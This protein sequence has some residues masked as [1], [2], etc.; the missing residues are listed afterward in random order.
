MSIEGFRPALQQTRHWRIAPHA[1]AHLRAELPA[2]IDPQR[3]HAALGQLLARHE[4][5]RTRLTAVPGMQLPVQVIAEELNFSWQVVE[6]STADAE[7]RLQ[8]ELAAS[9]AN[10][11][12]PPLAAALLCNGPSNQLLLALPAANADAETLELLLSELAALYQGQPLD[13]EPV[14]YADFAEWQHELISGPDGDAGRAFWQRQQAAELLSPVHP[15]QNP[16]AEQGYRPARIEKNLSASAHDRLHSTL[17]GLAT[18]PATVFGLCWAAL[19]QR[20]LGLPR[21]LLGCCHAGRNDAT[22]TAFG[23]YAKALP[24]LFAVDENQSLAALCGEFG[25]L[26]AEAEAWQESWPGEA[27]GLPFSFRYSQSTPCAWPIAELQADGDPAT[28]MLDV[29][30]RDGQFAFAL[31]YDASRFTGH[32]AELILEQFLS[33]CEQACSASQRPL[34]EASGIGAR[35]AEW[36]AELN[37][38]EAHIAAPALLHQLFEAQIEAN[39]TAIALSH[40]GVQLSYA[41]LE[42]QANRLAHRLR[43][44]GL[45]A[46]QP[47]GLFLGR[48]SEAIV[49][50]LGILKAGGAYLPLDPAY[51]AERLADMLEQTQAPLLL[52]VSAL[53]ERLPVG[54][55]QTLW[56]DGEDDAELP[57]Q[58][59][60]AIGH[61]DQLA[62]L[63]FT[64]G[65]TGRPKGVMVSHR[66]AVHSTSARWLGYQEPLASFLLVSGLAFDS[67]VAGLFWSLSQGGTLC[68]PQD[69]QVQDTLALGRLIAE[70]RISHCL[71]LPSLY[72]QVLE[73][74]GEHLSSLRCA[75]VAGEA[76]QA[77]VA[78]RHHE[79]C[80]GAALYNEYGP[81]EGSVWCSLYRSRGEEQ[82]VL[83]IGRAIANMRVQVLDER[84]QAVAPGVAGEIYIGGAGITQGYLGRP[85]L[86]AERYL[87]DPFG[88]PG[89]RLYRSG[90][91]GRLNAEGELEF[92][93]RVD[94][95][96]KIRGF[97]IELGEIEA[98]LLEH[99][100]L[101][102]AAVIARQ[103]PA[104]DAELVAYI[105]ARD[106]CP[107]AQTLRQHLA[108]HLPEHML[109]GAYVVLPALPLTPNGKLDR[110]ALPAPERGGQRAYRAPRNERES[111]LAGLWAEVLGVEKAGLDDHFFELGGHSLTA[112]RLISR[113]RS[114]L[115]IEV[116]VRALFLHPT[117]LGFAEQALPQAGA[118]ALPPIQAVV[119]D[120]ALPLSFAQERLWLFDRLHSGTST[121]NVAEA[122]RLSGELDQPALERSFAELLR[123]HASLRTRFVLENGQPLQYIDAPHAFPLALLDL[124]GLSETEREQALRSQLDGL[125]LQPFDL[126]RGPLIRAGL[127]R[128]D[129]HNHVLWLCLHHIVTDGWSM[130]VLTR[131]LIALYS[132]FSAG[133][134]SPLHEPALQYA[135]FAHW[136]RR[137][138]SP[139]ALKPQL[140]FWLAHLGKERPLLQLPGMRPRPALPSHRGA[141]HEFSLDSELTQALH[142]LTQQRGVT[143]FSTLLAAFKLLL[144]G[145]SGQHDIRIGI[146]I[147]NRNQQALEGLIGFFVNTLALRSDLSGNPSFEAL[148]VQ[149]H[150][151]MLAAHDH[152]DLPFEQLL[153]ALPNTQQQSAPL[154]QV[155]FD[156]HRERILS[157]SEFGNLQIS[158][159]EEGSNHSTLFDLMLDIGE[160]EHGLVA[161]FTYSSDLFEP[162][163]IALLAEDYRKMLR[164]VVQQP[165]ATLEQL[166]DQLSQPPNANQRS[167]LKAETQVYALLEDLLEQPFLDPQSNFFEQGG[168]SLK[169]VLLCAR[170]QDLWG[171]AIPP[172]LVFLHP[173]LAELVRVLK[174][175]SGGWAH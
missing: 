36:L 156:L 39:P 112:T 136:Q 152:Q 171:T 138:L 116:P 77:A 89:S 90:D 4:I 80:A 115:N 44:A 160:R 106:A 118:P 85:D 65:S 141:Q 59:P 135:D 52:S 8:A 173:Q 54:N 128:L 45:Q 1:V 32:A 159:I 18:Q 125:A 81:T 163:H 63:I 98:R 5:L 169:A 172:Q 103:N 15:W 100:A 122:V 131:E 19:L 126:A 142:G 133:Q 7:A 22:Q 132:A 71:M 101:R 69:G 70:Q 87:P 94:H 37:R 88:A 146:P 150:D 140:D 166:S 129:A 82:G 170:L 61:P 38:T 120:S 6:A 68:L 33:L 75:I 95:Q 104:G 168:T 2:A 127:M 108:E 53:S 174:P 17:A 158:P 20:H 105:V 110:A 113:L 119:G 157:S 21:L 154:L 148:L 134:P 123:R 34:R 93:G 51:P 29:Q 175:Y 149:L 25:A 72:A 47:V 161:T 165:Q 92:L 151:N 60:A 109:P 42:R 145:H 84:L 58:R 16:R 66:N 130:R 62:Y 137:Q 40:G 79:V 162:D 23:A 86:T 96:V 57:E 13:D 49:A 153:Q 35:Q 46:G 76:C 117:L 144:A 9:A 67:S 24:L 31:R 102:E 111:L 143:L 73:Q 167:A 48:S 27:P 139:E 83:P 55:Y 164:S 3:L 124:S 147:A 43:Q 56:L 10:P 107:G 121:Y 50:I 26:L 14:Q 99:P 155:M 41:E 30:A 78:A 11:E 64:S 91:I 114:A 28:L 97:R 74:S 12:Q